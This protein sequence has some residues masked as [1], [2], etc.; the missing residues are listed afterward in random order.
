[1]NLMVKKRKPGAGR[2]K[3]S[4]PPR[5]AVISFRVTS[6]YAVWFAGFVEHCSGAVGYADLPSH[7]VVLQAIASYAKEKDYEEEPPK[8]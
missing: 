3:G 6:A 5:D 2:P 8:R 4:R 1:M 7:A